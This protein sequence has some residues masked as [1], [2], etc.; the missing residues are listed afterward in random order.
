MLSPYLKQSLTFK[1][2]MNWKMDNQREEPAKRAACLDDGFG[3][4]TAAAR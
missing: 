1:L 3:M 2:T 4:Y